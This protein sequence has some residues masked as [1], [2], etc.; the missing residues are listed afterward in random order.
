MNEFTSKLEVIEN[1]A[2][3]LTDRVDQLIGAVQ[4]LKCQARSKTEETKRHRL[5][6][7]LMN[8]RDFRWIRRS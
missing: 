5:E 7:E 3:Q 2:H 1:E 8:M 4:H 6:V